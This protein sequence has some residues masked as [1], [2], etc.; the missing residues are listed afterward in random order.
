MLAAWVLYATVALATPVE[1]PPGEDS[2][3]R[4]ALGLSG[5]EPGPVGPGAGVRLLVRGE[6]L[7]IWVRD[8]Q[9]AEHELVV[10][11]PRTTQERESVMALAASLVQPMRSASLPGLELPAP[12]PKPVPRP[13]PAP[14]PAEPVPVVVA[15]PEP[16]PVPEPAPEAALVEEPSRPPPAPR[17]PPLPAL[18]MAPP[19]PIERPPPLHS[20]R[21]FATLGPSLRMRPTLRS[22]AALG[23]SL[24]LARGPW[25][26]A[27]GVE[28][29]LPARLLQLEVERYLT[30]VDLRAL[31]AWSLQRW[32]LGPTL[33][34]SI[35]KGTDPVEPPPPLML[36]TA[37]L[38]LARSWPMGSVGLQVGLQVEVDLIPI[39]LELDE[40]ELGVLQPVSA[41]LGT[42]L[43]FGAR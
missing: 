9:G 19:A 7:S 15:A 31:P 16:V 6:Q 43:L 4:S 32:A 42:A 13:R 27:L 24:G 30:V 5:L 3:W 38:S 29:V 18:Q 12:A 23:G 1:L 25:S 17:P 37:G 36:P 8:V 22:T 28:G 2:A 26:V 11:R 33:G 20:T 34:L 35:R 21:L 10:P 40:N 39:E 41:G 14:V